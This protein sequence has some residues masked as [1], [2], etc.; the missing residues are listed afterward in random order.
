MNI[1][2]PIRYTDLRGEFVETWSEK[3][4]PGYD[5][6]R[7]C[8]S[9]SK[10]RVLRGIHGDEKTTKLVSCLAGNALVAV[11]APDKSFELIKLSGENRLRILVPP[12]W[13]LAYYA[14][15]DVIFSYKQDSDHEE[16]EQFTWKWNSLGI[17]WPYMNPILSG[18]DD[19]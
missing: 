5:W 4:L 9:A 10:P 11:V 2:E 16:F 3:S 8:I 17:P 6:K 18:R 7:D 19:I 15:N 13:G 1:L 14:I 12:K